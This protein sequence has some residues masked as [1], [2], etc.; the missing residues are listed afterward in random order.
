MSHLL[1]REGT[2]G[3][4]ILIGFRDHASQPSCKL[5]EKTFE[6]FPTLLCVQHTRPI[7]VVFYILI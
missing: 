6:A 4:A 3:Y 2:S 5:I 7:N 1:I